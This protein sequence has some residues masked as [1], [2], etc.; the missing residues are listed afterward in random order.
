MCCCKG[1][2]GARWGA[3]PEKVEGC[4][5]GMAHEGGA[6]VEAVNDAYGACDRAGCIAV[7]EVLCCASSFIESRQI[8]DSKAKCTSSIR[9]LTRL[10]FEMPTHEIT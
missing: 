2:C 1:A 6:L 3:S 10:R 8:A 7:R 5:F 9:T 4:R